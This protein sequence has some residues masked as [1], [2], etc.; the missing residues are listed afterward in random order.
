MKF[1]LV[2]STEGIFEVE[3]QVY[4]IVNSS[5]EYIRVLDLDT[6]E[7]AGDFERKAWG[8]RNPSRSGRE[9]NKF[10][11]KLPTDITPMHVRDNKVY[12]MEKTKAQYIVYD[13]TTLE[14]VN[15]YPI[16]QLRHTQLLS[17]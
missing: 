13:A 17:L 4:G 8:T 12:A 5:D 16:T 7:L 9:A 11:K 10:I 1:D 3:N 6:G 14:V 15:E 2:N